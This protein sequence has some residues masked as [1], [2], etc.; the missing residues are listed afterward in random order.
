MW[1]LNILT[2]FKRAL[3][4]F[5]NMFKWARSYNVEKLLI[6]PAYIEP[7][8]LQYVESLINDICYRTWRWSIS[9]SYGFFFIRPFAFSWR[10]LKY[11]VRHPASR[12][13]SNTSRR[14]FHLNWRDYETCQCFSK[15]LFKCVVEGRQMPPSL[16][17]SLVYLL[18]CHMHVQYWLV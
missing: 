2:F 7:T 17:M 12:R 18:S 9:K 4:S 14:I 5:S 6:F 3:I 16:Y 13:L 11:A 10:C 1:I 15:P 8:L